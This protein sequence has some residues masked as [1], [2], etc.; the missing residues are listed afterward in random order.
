MGGMEGSTMNRQMSKI[1]TAALLLGLL[2]AATP[3]RAE[4]TRTLTNLKGEQVTV[5]NVVPAR[6]ELA[7]FKMVVVKIETPNGK[8]GLVFS[9]YGTAVSKRPEEATYV[10][11]YDLAG[12]L[13][14]ITWL[15]ESGQVKV[16]H[17]KNLTDPDAKEPAKVL[18]MGAGHSFIVQRPALYHF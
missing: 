9:L 14:E 12:N 6:E 15:D 10:E 8:G 3:S 16:A 2:L 1:A 4:E 5:P 11:L 7:L 18:V 17:D 13:L